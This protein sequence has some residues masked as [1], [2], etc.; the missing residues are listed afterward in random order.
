MSLLCTV[1]VLSSDSI[2]PYAV[3]VLSSDSN[4]TV[5]CHGVE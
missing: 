5:C 3:T 4:P 2:L 1:T